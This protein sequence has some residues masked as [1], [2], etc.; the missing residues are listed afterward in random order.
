MALAESIVGLYMA[1]VIRPRGPWRGPEPVEFGT[2]EV[3]GCSKRLGAAAG[4]GGALS[5]RGAH[6]VGRV[7]HTK[8][9]PENPAR[10]TAS[11][12]YLDKP[13]CAAWR[14]TNAPR[15]TFSFRADRET[16]HPVPVLHSTDPHPR[17]AVVTQ[18]TPTERSQ[19]QA[20]ND[21]TDNWHEVVKR[22]ADGPHLMVSTDAGATLKLHRFAVVGVFGTRGMG[23]SFTLG[24]LVENFAA[25]ADKATVVLDVQNQFWTMEYTP[26][27]H[28]EEYQA[29]LATLVA[30][31]LQPI[32]TQDVV[33]WS[34]C[35][36]DPL[37]PRARFFR[38][39]PEHLDPDDWLSILDLERYSPMGQALIELLRKPGTSDAG[40]LARMLEAGALPTYQ[41]TTTDGLRWRLDSLHEIGLIGPSGLAVD[42]L[43][44]GG[45]TSIF[46]LRNLPDSSSSRIF[47]QVTRPRLTAHGGNAPV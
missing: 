32:F 26:D 16:P 36:E 5:P 21:V 45:R 19:R 2:L 13:P 31:N 12:S 41:Q 1:E 6:G 8:R 7:T 25:Q 43:L 37:F 9:P 22:R 10:F 42:E 40:Q 38:L 44:V 29:H 3:A 30:W 24:V 47:I 17:P 20:T 23:K 4:Q 34:P 33:Q 11:S 35:R 28:L 27:S 39:A 15:W 46:L 14:T 18:T